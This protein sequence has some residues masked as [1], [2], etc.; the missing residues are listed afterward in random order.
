MKSSAPVDRQTKIVAVGCY[1][2]PA[3]RSNYPQA[4]RFGYEPAFIENKLGFTAVAVKDADETTLDMCLRAYQ[5]LRS[6]V[7]PESLDVQLV[8]VVTQN[9]TSRIPHVSAVLH[10]ALGLGA[11]CMTFDISQG[12]SGFVHALAIVSATMDS[13]HLDSALIFTSD[14]Y[15][16]IL[17]QDDK[18]TIMIFGDGATVT[19]LTRTPSDGFALIDAEF[20]TSPGSDDCLALTGQCLKM[21]GRRVFDYAARAVPGSITR[22]LDRNHLTHADVDLYLLHQGSKFIVDSL[23]KLLRIESCKAPF[24]AAEYGNTVA[25]SIPMLLAKYFDADA[26]SHVIL[27]GFGVGFTWGTCLLAYSKERSE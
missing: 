11:G 1:L 23:A 4:E 22:I 9:P 3:R 25:S 17:D 7:E 18:N 20:G 12:C 14:P 27:S 26:R 13:L 21:D 15:Q 8:T 19:L 2:P 5:D 6:K 10:S 16:D 24:A